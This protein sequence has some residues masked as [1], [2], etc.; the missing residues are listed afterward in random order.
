MIYDKQ[1]NASGDIQAKIITWHIKT[2]LKTIKL[3]LTWHIKTLL[4][5]LRQKY[6]IA[7]K[8]ASGDIKISMAY[9]NAPGNN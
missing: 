4:G 1:L 3:T 2:P 5:T 7:Y 6:N 9:K 8:N